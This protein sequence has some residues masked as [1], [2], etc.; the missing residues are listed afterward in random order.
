ME[1]QRQV[2]HPGLTVLSVAQRDFRASP[3][4]GQVARDLDCRAW[5]PHDACHRRY[6]DGWFP[7]TTRATEYGEQLEIVR[8]AASDAERDP[9]A[10]TP[11]LIRFIVTGR[12]RNEID[13]VVDSD[14]A[15]VFTLNCPAKDWA[16][17]GA[18]H[19]MGADFTGVQDLIPQTIDEQ[20][21]LSYA[22][23][24]PRSLVQEL[25]AVGTPDEVIEQIAE[26]RDHGL[27]YLVVG[28]AGAIQPSLRKSASATARPRTSLT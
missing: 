16:R 23:K 2:G 25:F 11:A 15:Q 14:I 10:I 1:L 7:G 12:S 8:T 18:E 5:A 22:A 26:F 9:M 19:P 24:V 4:Q 27:Q 17:H 20:T 6:A 13:E 21:A 28:N 3:V